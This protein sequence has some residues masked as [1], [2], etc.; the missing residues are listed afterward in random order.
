MT[1]DATAPRAIDALGT[2]LW[3][4]FWVGVAFAVMVLG[5]AGF[6]P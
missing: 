1:A 5:L 6:L 2:G 3:A 4:G